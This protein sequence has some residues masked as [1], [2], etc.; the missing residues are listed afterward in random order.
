MTCRNKGCKI[1]ARLNPRTGLCPS[2]DE[3]VMSTARRLENN[4]RQQHAREASHDAH[5][6]L[7]DDPQ[8]QDPSLPHGNN[9]FDF[10]TA[11]TSATQPLPNIDLNDIIKNC[12]EAK[13]GNPVDTGKVLGDMLGMI[14]HMFARQSD[15]DETKGVVHSNTDRIAHLE[16][17]V[18][19]KDDVAYPRSIAIRKLPLPPL[20]VSELQN[21]QHYLK[22]VNAQGVDV[23]RDTVKAIRKESMKHDPTLGPNLGTVLVELSDDETRGK[24]MK[25]K[26][27]LMNHSN[28]ILKNLI[29]K[30]A[31]TPAEMKAQNT[32]LG[33]L[34]LITG[35]NEYF[36]AGN[37][38]IRKKDH[39]NRPPPPPNQQHPN[40]HPQNHPRP[41]NQNQQVLPNPNHQQN[42]TNQRRSPPRQG[43]QASSQ[44]RQSQPQSSQPRSFPSQ[45]APQF[46]YS[47][48]PS[49]PPN[50]FPQFPYQRFPSFPMPPPGPAVMPRNQANIVTNLLDFDFTPVEAATQ[51][52]SA[53]AQPRPASAQPGNSSSDSQDEFRTEPN[54][55][56][57]QQ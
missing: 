24:I 7:D 41:A 9:I 51:P 26:K 28:M 39:N 10:P 36:I 42:A 33:I 50:S 23:T 49:F 46:V 16:A 52:R 44:A 27:N 11:S 31:M 48:T 40:Q 14:V 53:S 17:K 12:E 8:P 47:Q 15:I 19:G 25:A 56:P 34:N 45:S 18:G 1:K 4:D 6:N 20:G 22:E 38:S 13:K 32:N 37:G 3:F 55:S 57:Q 5:R 35:N 30:N 54:A 2:C 29:I 21:A 43:A